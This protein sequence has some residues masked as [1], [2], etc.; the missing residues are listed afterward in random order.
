[1]RR[2]AL[3]E[4]RFGKCLT[5]YAPHL[6]QFSAG[7]R[8]QQ[9]VLRWPQSRAGECAIQP[10]TNSLFPGGRLL[11]IDS[12]MRVLD[13]RTP[14]QNRHG[15]LAEAIGRGDTETEYFKFKCFKN[16]NLH[17]EFKRL[18]LVQR[19]NQIATGDLVIGDG[20]VTSACPWGSRV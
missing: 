16:G 15:E 6:A 11:A 14:I 13:G 10:S 3:Q 20:E 8:N 9:A 5:T 1:M 18:D 17:L 2:T 12:V 7:V 19:L 4:T